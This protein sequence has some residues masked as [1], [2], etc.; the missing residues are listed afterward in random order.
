MM[1]KIKNKMENSKLAGSFKTA[2]R[3]LGQKAMKKEQ[4]IDGILVTVGLCIIALILCIVMKDS[5]KTFIETIVSSMT[6]QAQKILS[7]VSGTIVL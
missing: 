5:M 1:L 3:S 7:G 6:S 4:G 2:V